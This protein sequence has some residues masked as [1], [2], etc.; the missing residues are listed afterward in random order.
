MQYTRKQ[1]GL[2]K[3]CTLRSAYFYAVLNCADAGIM[4]AKDAMTLCQLASTLVTAVSWMHPLL[5]PCCSPGCLSS[6][7]E[8]KLTRIAELPHPFRDQLFMLG[9]PHPVRC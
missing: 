6:I 2:E 9:L 1:S 4:D 5:Q 7:Q 8:W 3:V